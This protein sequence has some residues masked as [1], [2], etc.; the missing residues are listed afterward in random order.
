M[1]TKKTGAVKILLILAVIL[2]MTVRMSYSAQVEKTPKEIITLADEYGKTDTEKYGNKIYITSMYTSYV[3]TE[4]TNSFKKIAEGKD[5]EQEMIEEIKQ[6][7]LKAKKKIKEAKTVLEAI[8]VPSGYE[9]VQKKI[10]TF[11]GELLGSSDLIIDGAENK[12]PDK[13]AAGMDKLQKCTNLLKE[14]LNS[15]VAKGYKPSQ[16][17]YKIVN[18]MYKF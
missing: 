14:G 2:I 18:D 13:V 1:A 16:K 5:S 7:T 12:D 17:F 4:M 3:L 9:D 11:H 15:L 8:K 6:V 10:V